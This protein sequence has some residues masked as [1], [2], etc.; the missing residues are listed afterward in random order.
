MSCLVMLRQLPAAVAADYYVPRDSVEFTAREGLPNLFKKLKQ[1]ENVTIAYLGGSITGQNGWRVQS[2]EWFEEEYPDAKIRGI[3][4]AIAGTGSG[5]GVYRLEQDALVS[6][7][8]LL[9]VEF[10]VNDIGAPPENITRAMEGIVRK[11]W[12]INPETDICF[13]Y[14]MTFR[15]YADLANGKMMRSVSV[16]EA[17]A[18]HYGIPSVH[19]GYKAALMEKAGSLIIKTDA[20]PTPQVSGDIINGDAALATDE[21][22]RI[23]FSKDGTHPYP[24]TGHVLYTQ[25]LIRSFEQ[26]QENAVSL[27][28]S[29]P[30]PIREDNL[31]GASLVPVTS[32]YLSGNY[33]A[34][35]GKEYMRFNKW[36]GQLYRLEPGAALAFKFKGTEVSIYDLMGYDSSELEV[37]LDGREWTAIRMDGHCTYRRVKKLEVGTK[38]KDSIHEVTVRVLGNKFNKRDMLFESNQADYDKNSGKY[39]PLYW[40]TGAI[41]IVGEIVE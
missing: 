20:I 16:M 26:I 32:E 35:L 6:R 2:Q 24:A 19:M 12:K 5:L 4:A 11:T 1:G 9:F 22:G 21:K 27:S 33:T 41:M 3:N 23:I 25:A 30:A 39:E 38:L 7:P 31:E 29:L 15:E 34:M 17:V 8:D 18:D 37:T 36:M 28:H 13:V 14:T 40:Y 10:A